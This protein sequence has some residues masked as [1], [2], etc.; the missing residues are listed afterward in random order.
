MAMAYDSG[1]TVAGG[2]DMDDI[3][4]NPTNSIQ[5]LRA[6]I[7]RAVERHWLNPWCGICHSRAL[8]YEDSAT[9][10]ATLEEAMPYIHELEQQ[11]ALA[12][13]LF[14]QTAQN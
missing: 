8:T 2:S 7:Q 14:G 5:F 9:A 6:T 12:R 11:Q 13:S 4:L 10:F 3:V 1:K